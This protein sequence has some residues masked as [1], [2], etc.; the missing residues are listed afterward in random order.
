MSSGI[1]S[2]KMAS[3]D[4]AGYYW[5][6]PNDPNT[7]LD[8]TIEVVY[9]YHD[10]GKW[11]VFRPGETKSVSFSDFSHWFGPVPQPELPLVDMII[12]QLY[13]YLTKNTLT[14]FQEWFVPLVWDINSEDKVGNLVHGIKLLIA[15]YTGGH[16]IEDFLKRGLF[17]LIKELGLEEN[18]IMVHECYSKK[19]SLVN[20]DMNYIPTE[21]NWGN[22]F[23]EDD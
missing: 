1:I 10:G 18:L 23:K 15:E 5:A 14:V 21:S 17:K 6:V 7:W 19:N 20:S 2:W 22:L 8:G 12:R 16:K 4:K 3:P 13:L 11:Q 9:V